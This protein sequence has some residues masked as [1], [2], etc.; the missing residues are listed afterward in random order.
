MYTG[1]DFREEHVLTDGTPIVLRHIRASDGEQ[2]RSAFQQLS[3]ESRYRRFFHSIGRLSDDM[4]R[5]L[6]DVDGK[7][8]VAIVA[9]KVSP[10]DLSEEGMGV[11][12]FVRLADEPTVAEM[13][14]TVLDDHQGKGLGNILLHAI[15]RAASERGIEHF[16]GEVLSENAPMRALLATLDAKV[17]ESDGES[18]VFDVALAPLL[19]PDR[20]TAG[21]AQLL[22]EAAAAVLRF[23]ERQV[24][25]KLT[26]QEE[27]ES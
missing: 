11:A 22:R 3:P 25:R 16:R 8:H 9:G 6:C 7:D 27:Q 15:A 1:A 5:Y 18:I 2:L 14:V 26:G 19:G 13:A 4:I 24:G 21:A 10:D 12:R 17:I 20:E 23:V